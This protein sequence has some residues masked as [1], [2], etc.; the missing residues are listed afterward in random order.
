[1]RI[2]Q[3]KRNISQ[4][5]L[6]L[7]EINQELKL[8]KSNNK[9]FLENISSKDKVIK[10]LRQNLKDNQRLCRKLLKNKDNLISGLQK[11]KQSKPKDIKPA[12]IIKKE[13]QIKIET[14]EQ[15]HEKDFVFDVLSNIG[16]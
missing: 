1:M 7:Q 5:R 16:K 11:L 9:T 12:T 3:L 14:G 8:C 2:E 4:I 15:L 6:Q 13:C 10:Q